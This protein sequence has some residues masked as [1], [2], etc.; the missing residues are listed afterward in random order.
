MEQIEWK[1]F[2]HPEFLKSLNL[3]MSDLKFLR[4]FYNQ[5]DLE[6]AELSEHLKPQTIHHQ[7]VEING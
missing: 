6:F 1:N 4:L 7:K 3:S 5:K 2:R